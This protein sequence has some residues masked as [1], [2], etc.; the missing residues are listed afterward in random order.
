MALPTLALCC[1]IPRFVAA[2]LVADCVDTRVRS[3]EDSGCCRWR[4]F[5]LFWSGCPASSGA[6]SIGTGNSFIWT[7]E[8]A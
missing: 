7:G 8:G 6:V 3:S 5:L 4:T 1:L 2:W